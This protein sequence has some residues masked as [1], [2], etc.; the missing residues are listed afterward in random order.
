[1][2][3]FELMFT[4]ILSFILCYIFTPFVRGMAVRWKIGEKPNG[5]TSR[6][7]AHIGGISIIAAI[8]LTLIPVFLFYLPGNPFHKAF[9]PILIVSGFLIFLL[10]IVDDLRSLHYLY[11]LFFQILVALVVSVGGLGLL[12]HFAIVSLSVEISL[13]VFFFVSIWMIVITTSFNLI[14]GLDGLSSGIALIASSAFAVSGIIFDQPI[15][16]AMSLVVFGSVLAFLRY[17]FPPAKIL[18]GDSGSMFLGLL[19]GLISLMFVIPGDELFHRASG[20]ITI[21]ALPLID[22]SLAFLR[23]LL[24]DRR[25]FEADMLHVHHILLYRFKSVIIVDI[26]LWALSAVFAVLGVFTMLGNNYTLILA[27]SIATVIF[28]RLLYSMVHFGLSRE[29][30]I[31]ILEKGDVT[32][33]GIVRRGS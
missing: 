21:L 12:E 31:E 7:I 23:R 19:F 29:E 11:K 6:D 20:V 25:I 9:L 18:M 26:L 3:L 15:I 30:A 32:A 13:M 2:T 14:D 27:G 5:R 17:N 24:M 28:F 4:F 22:T 16:V 8:L 10:G 1:L 33:S